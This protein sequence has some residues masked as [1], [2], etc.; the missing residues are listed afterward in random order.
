MK[1]PLEM[2]NTAG[3]AFDF[4]LFT[5]KLGGRVKPFKKSAFDKT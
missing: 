1:A 4:P 2:I 3:T 5:E